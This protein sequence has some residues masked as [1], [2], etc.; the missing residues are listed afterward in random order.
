MEVRIKEVKMLKTVLWWFSGFAG[1]CFL[2]ALMAC[3]AKG[4]SLTLTGVLTVV[5]GVFA[6]RFKGK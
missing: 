4:L 5:L 3:P 6:W 2:G 1:G